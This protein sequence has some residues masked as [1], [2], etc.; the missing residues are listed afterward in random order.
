MFARVALD[1]PV[2]TEFTYSVPESLADTVKLGQRVRVP[3][4]ASTRVGYLVGLDE[5]TDVEK[6]RDLSGV[7]DPQPMVP[8]DLLELA[9]W[10]SEYYCCALGEALQ[11]MLPGG[12]RRGRPKV[13]MVERVAAGEAPKRAKKAAALLLALDG[14][15]KTTPLKTLLDKAGVSRAALKT[16]EKAGLVRI[17]ERAADAT[18]DLSA[19]AVKDTPPVLEAAQAD[20]VVAVC[21]DLVDHAFNVHLLLGVTGSGKTE[22]YL[23]SIAECVSRGKQAIVLVPEIA[24]TPQ[25]VR[26]FR[27]RFDRVAVLHSAQT[28]AER[29]DAWQT[30]RRG[31]ADVVVGPRSAVFAPVSDLGLVVVDEE[32]ENSFKQENVPRYHARD[33]AVVRA[34]QAN[35]P[36]LLGSAT[37]SLESYSNARRGR[38][39]LHRLPERAGGYPLPPVQ[40]VDMTPEAGRIFSRQ[41]MN[42]VSD[43]VAAGGQ[44]I[45]FLNRRGFA[46]VVVCTRCKNTLGCPNCSSTLVFHKGRKTTACHL[47]G[48]E[49]RLLPKCPECHAPSLKFVG[50]GTERVF[51]AAL[52]AWPAVPTVR[53]DSDTAR[54]DKLT[55]ALDRF[56]HGE[57]RIMIGTQMVAKG[58]HFPDVTLV[59]IVNADTAMHLPDFRANERTFSLI[60]QVAGR[61]GRGDRGGRV[62][63]QTFNPRHYAVMSAAQHDFEG[64]AKQE[65]EERNMLGLPP[66]QRCALLHISSE[67]MNE[68]WAK[69]RLIAETI[70]PL[71]KDLKVEIRGPAKAPIERV[72]S[73][74]RIMILLLAKSGRALGRVCREA[75][76]VKTGSKVDF[77]ADVDPSAVL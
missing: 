37:P 55:E 77:A 48:H 67:L 40:I 29:R 60:A 44:V 30:I 15:G 62:I 56:R 75:R 57:A 70:R 47:C 71:A 20:V 36:V 9:R 42:G 39:V 66:A 28:E 65:L 14:F 64:F 22:V 49:T 21:E 26:R 2:P 46:T 53:V 3:F 24:L 17:V 59:G 72:R 63:V 11:A 31:D 13:K 5:E 69:A 7:V 73:R 43:A 8:P 25:T 16:L 58:H 61:A 32:H 45:L 52:R 18:A 68:A 41:L 34:K 51:E 4:R 10:I 23:R 74:W 1:L 27:A 12:V 54:G 33:V 50:S 38:Y 35:C 19:S 6:T 76:K